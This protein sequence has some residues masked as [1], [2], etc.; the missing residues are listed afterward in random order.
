MEFG[1]HSGLAR[2]LTGNEEAKLVNVLTGC[3][4]IEYARS[5][6]QVLALVRGVLS[7]NS[8]S[9]VISTGWF[10]GFKCRHPKLTLGKPDKLSYIRS[11]RDPEIIDH[12]FDL[13]EEN[14]GGR[15][16]GQALPDL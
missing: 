3:S 12:Y 14:S 15:S 6:Q 4:A 10:E 13:L 5:K 7:Q 2:Y 9:G 8:Q 1:A 16:D 11:S